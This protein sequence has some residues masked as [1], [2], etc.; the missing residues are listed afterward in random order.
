MGKRV[1]V[2][3]D[4]RLVRDLLVEALSGWGISPE[5]ADGGERAL[6]ILGS[7]DFDL[8]ITDA[9]M[10]GVTGLELLREIK[11][12]YPDLKVIV[13][14][15]YAREDDIARYVVAGADA[16]LA[17]PILME[18]LRTLVEEILSKTG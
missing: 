15:G 10:P 17:K 6:E 9:V 3:D 18:E 14:T 16:Y 1:L 12:E 11:K 8:V 2:V 4:E 13:I 5:A 7:G